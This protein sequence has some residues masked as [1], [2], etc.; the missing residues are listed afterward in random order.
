MKFSIMVLLSVFFGT[1]N[2]E[3]ASFQYSGDTTGAAT[4]NRPIEG[5]PPSVLS[6]IGDNV[7]YSVQAFNVGISGDYSFEVISANHFDPYLFLYQGSFNP[8]NP[9]ASNSVLDGNDDQTVG[10]SLPKFS[11][12]L[13]TNT[14]YYLVTT[15]FQNT[16]AGSF[17]NVI[18]GVGSIAPIPEPE[19]WAMMMAGAVIISYQVRRKKLAQCSI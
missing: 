3:A 10:N 19:E 1:L 9:L 7:P 18:S 8:A 13:A 17:T 12:S 16:D 15:G 6:T 2:A 11:H 14:K 5:T 4:W